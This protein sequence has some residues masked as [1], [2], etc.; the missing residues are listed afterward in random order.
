[1]G[2]V[3]EIL[4]IVRSAE[5]SILLKDFNLLIKTGIETLRIFECGDLVFNENGSYFAAA[6]VLVTYRHYSFLFTSHA[7]LLQEL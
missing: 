1:M 7:T 5:L 6:V 3:N 2:N 4:Q